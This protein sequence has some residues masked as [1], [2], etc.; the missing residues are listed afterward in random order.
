MHEKVQEAGGVGRT[1]RRDLGE[2]RVVFAHQEDGH[3]EYLK[4]STQGCG[5][6]VTFIKIEKSHQTL[7]FW[8]P[9]GET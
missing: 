5:H 1:R 3:M 9:Y 2:G 7:I 6:R 4:S 8:I